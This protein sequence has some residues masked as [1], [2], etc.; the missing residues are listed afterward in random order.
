[1][2]KSSVTNPAQ[3]REWRSMAPICVLV[4]LTILLGFQFSSWA[5]YN[6]PLN[7]LV[8]WW[9]ADGNGN[10]SAST[11]NGTVANNVGFVPGVSGQA[12]SCPGLFPGIV[13]VPDCDAFKLTNS[14]T[15]AAWVNMQ[16][17]S[18]AVM[19]RG[20]NYALTF[21]FAGHPQFIIGIGA[22]AGRLTPT[23]VIPFNRWT[24][25]AGTLDGST[26]DMRLYVN[27]NLIAETNTAARPPAGIINADGI[28]IGAVFTG[29]D[30]FSFNGYIDEV[31]LYSR[32]LSPSEIASVASTNGNG[33]VPHGAT[34]IATLVNGFVVGINITDAGCGYTNTPLVEIVGG[35]GSNAVATATVNNGVVTGITV[36]NAGFGYTN[37]PDV[38]IVS[39][40]FLSWL[41]IAISQFRVTEHVVLGQNYQLQS[42]SDMVNWVPAGPPFT[43]QTEVI[44]QVFDAEE[45]GRYFRLLQLP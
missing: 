13:S 30:P 29:S 20:N 36:L 23:N 33:C 10:D 24:H 32:A 1:M 45:T 6:P 34:A 15:M 8:S 9:R 25:L 21:D 14:L 22:A 44:T 2:K 31:L 40:P 12:F 28:G 18:W 42:S 7:G 26:G 19:C 11:N 37:V 16:N 39:P 17:N 27:G 35:G 38:L 5:Q 4:C 3:T 43:A 41:E